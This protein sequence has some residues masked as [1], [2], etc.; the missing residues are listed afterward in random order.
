MLSRLPSRHENMSGLV[1]NSLTHS[2][3]RNTRKTLNL[4]H[5]AAGREGDTH[6]KTARPLSSRIGQLCERVSE[7]CVSCRT[8]GWWVCLPAWLCHALCRRHS[9]TVKCIRREYSPTQRCK[10]N[11]NIAA[12]VWRGA[13]RHRCGF[14]SA[15][16]QKSLRYKCT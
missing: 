15:S 7:S 9:V 14:E 1:C 11:A 13:V 2:H 3:P 5:F 16:A 8:N 10:C 6:R 4:V 12:L